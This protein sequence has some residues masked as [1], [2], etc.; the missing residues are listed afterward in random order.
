MLFEF[1]NGKNFRDSYIKNIS[2]LNLTEGKKLDFITELDSIDNL[3]MQRY[4]KTRKWANNIIKDNLRY[5]TDIIFQLFNVYRYILYER[6]DTC[7]S[8]KQNVNFERLLDM[9]TNFSIQTIEL[10]KTTIG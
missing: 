2:K 5:I 6:I 8:E 9:A 3:F 1:N 10:L 4:E 7:D